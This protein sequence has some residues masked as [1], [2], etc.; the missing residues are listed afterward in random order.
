MTR[1]VR[2]SPL[3]D[4]RRHDAERSRSALLKAAFQEFSAR[5]FAGARVA[6]IARVAGVNKQLI[7]Y[8][9]GG[10]EGLYKALHELWLSE[11]ERFADRS[12]SLADLTARYLEEEFR[13]PSWARL[14]LWHGLDLEAGPAPT[15]REEDLSWLEQRQKDG[16]IAADLDPGF[17]LLMLIGAVSAPI[18][19]REE[20]VRIT[21]L[22]PD[23]EE[24]EQRY[25]E[26][27]R[28]LVRHLGEDKPD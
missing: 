22:D 12:L 10:K 15:P 9:F 5:G 27:L 21:G 24:F 6:E 19:L 28:R 25:A 11:E 8:Y 4:E 2:R 20:V 3:P 23:S 14:A 16:E 17:V 1:Q 13:D 18:A 26:Q 7:T